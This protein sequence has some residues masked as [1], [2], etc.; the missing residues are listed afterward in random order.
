MSYVEP[1]VYVINLPLSS[2]VMSVIVYARAFPLL[3]QLYSVR[4]PNI[5]FAGSVI[6]FSV[7]YPDNIVYEPPPLILVTYVHVVPS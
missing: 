4:A 3:L 2:L 7:R 1:N 6:P 5:I